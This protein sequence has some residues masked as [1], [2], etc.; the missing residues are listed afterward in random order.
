MAEFFI[1]YK[2]NR[3]VKRDSIKRSTVPFTKAKRVGILFTA[4]DKE[5]FLKVK[6]LYTLLKNEGKEVEVMTYL[7]KGAQNYEFLF[8]IFDKKGF[9]FT[10]KV[11]DEDLQAFI[12]SEFDYLLHL[13]TE[14]TTFTDYILATTMARCR[15]GK[16]DAERN[17]LYE[18]MLNIKNKES[19]DQLIDQISY[20]TRRI[21]NE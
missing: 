18:L 3:S 7:A 5:K 19:Y 20:Y 9:S 2:T 14:S 16:Y 15:V 4:G 13:D 11:L 21:T 6:E 10:G 1:K 8:K 12:D 17:R